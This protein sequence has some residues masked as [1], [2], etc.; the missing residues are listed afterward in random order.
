MAAS[1]SGER[2]DY[3]RDYFKSSN[4]D[5]FEIINKAILV[6]ASDYPKEFRF[7]R[8]CIAQT[9][10]SCKLIKCIGCDKVDIG[11]GFS[12]NDDDNCKNVN[13]CDDHQVGDYNYRVAEAL[14]DE[15]EAESQIFGEVLRIK[16]IVDSSQDESESVLYNSLRKLQLMDIS[17]ETLKAT[18]IGKSVNVLRKHASKDVS[19][20]ATTLIKLWK[21]MVD[22]WVR[23]TEKTVVS[24]ATPESLNPSVL[25][26]EEGLPSPPLDDLAFF[27]PH[28]SMELSEFFD[29]VEE[30]GN[31][32]NSGGFN[33]NYNGPK[34]NQQK[35]SNVPTTVRK[36]EPNTKLKKKQPTIVKPI[37]PLATESGPARQTKPN[38]ERK[39]ENVPK[40]PQQNNQRQSGEV[41]TQDKFEAAKRKLQER[42][43]QAENVKKQRTIQVMELQDL[44]KP[45]GLPIRN[46]Q[47]VRPGSNHNRRR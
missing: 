42:Y 29:G 26:E 12:I 28:S 44:P 1:K 30:Y 24:E 47:N 4:G 46:H 38:M 35:P 16:E 40:R 21:D 11:V 31:P 39:L 2:M 13:V 34:G 36:D 33:K 37:K 23:A 41:T 17:V 3:W 19:S 7:K 32:G 18:E 8:D 15:I 27:Y 6:A 43:Q 45:K 5:I 22:E 25:D 20:I 14:N 9:L 10:Y